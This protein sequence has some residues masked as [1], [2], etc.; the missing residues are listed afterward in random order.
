MLL[1]FECQCVAYAQWNKRDGIYFFLTLLLLTTAEL[2]HDYH[3]ITFPLQG[4]RNKSNTHFASVYPPDST[5]NSL[6]LLQNEDIW[7]R[8]NAVGNSLTNQDMAKG[9]VHL[10]MEALEAKFP[11]YVLRNLFFLFKQIKGGVQLSFQCNLN[12]L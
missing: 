11:Q 4:A 5:N 12:L 3:Y 1:G 7:W 2:Q 9:V 10:F 6:P 8:E